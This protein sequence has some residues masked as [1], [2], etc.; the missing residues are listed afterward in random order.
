M[1]DIKLIINEELKS[2]RKQHLTE[3]FTNLGKIENPDERL[4]EFFKVANTLIAEGYDDKEIDSILAEQGVMDYVGKGWDALTSD[5]SYN[6]TS[7]ASWSDMIGGGVGSLV[8]EKIIRYVLEQLG[9]KG[10]LVDSLVIG[11]KET[12]FSNFLKLFK[13][14]QLC[15]SAGANIAD[16]IMEVMIF[17][18]FENMRGDLGGSIAS[19]LSDTTRSVAR[20]MISKSTMGEV[21][22]TKFCREVIWQENKPKTPQI[23]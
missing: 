8:K 13:N 15:V 19:L 4:F 17:H 10:K 16:S 9:V 6:S 7:N 20:Q 23:R 22:S 12:P 3:S 21:V 11:L 14:E 1:K 2:K 5:K 18:A